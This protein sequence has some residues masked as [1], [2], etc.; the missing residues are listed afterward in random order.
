M[1]FEKTRIFTPV[2]FQKQLYLA[3]IGT[4]VRVEV[5]HAGEQKWLELV[6]EKRPEA[7]R[8]R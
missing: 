4:K 6:V 2:D 3:G 1:S 5:F 7:A 8:P